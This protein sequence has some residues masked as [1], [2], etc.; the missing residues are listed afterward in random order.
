MATQEHHTSLAT[1]RVLRS[2]GRTAVALLGTLVIF[3]LIIFI[4]GANP[5][6]AFKSIYDGSLG[7]KF[8]FGQTVMITSLLSLTGLAAAI[9]FSARLFNVGGEGQL[10]VGAI[11]GAG[12]A[13]TLPATTPH[14]TFVAA[15]VALSM[16]GGGVG[17]SVEHKY[18]SK[19]PK[20]RKGVVILHKA[21]KDASFIVP[22]SREG[23]CELI[24]RTLE[25]FFVT[26]KSFEYSTVCI[27]G[28]PLNRSWLFWV[29]INNDGRVSYWLRHIGRL[30]LQRVIRHAV[31]EGIVWK[32]SRCRFFHW[33]QNIFM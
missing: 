21:T 7:N 18:T 28:R 13:L 14:V 15:V 20:I 3:A 2:A 22:D 9:P 29:T 12:S 26:G 31:W 23:W 4:L 24:R 10:Y 11:V 25:A 1:N 32:I 6:S 27:R 30:R 16:L 19:L 17:M 33:R 5:L 8:N